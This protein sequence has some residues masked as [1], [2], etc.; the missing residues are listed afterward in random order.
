MPR[1]QPRQR[2]VH[3]PKRCTYQH[4]F[5]LVEVLAA[6]AIFSLFTVILIQVV[7]GI[8]NFWRQT[9]KNL[10]VFENARTLFNV[11]QEDI[12]GITTRNLENERI[13]VDA[14]GVGVRDVA[15]VTNSLRNAGP[16]STLTEVGYELSNNQLRRWTT[17]DIEPVKWNFLDADTSLWAADNSWEKVGT[18]ASGVLEFQLNFYHTSDIPPYISA[19]DAFSD[20]DTRPALAVVSFT[21]IHPSNLNSTQAYRL[22]RTFSTRIKLH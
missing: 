15:F 16:A 18:V 3:R 5:T 12:K 22:K 6:I 13:L 17:T 7:N 8:Q 2:C 21:L 20:S 9:T 1:R 4:S 10:E 11:I 14:N 19:Y